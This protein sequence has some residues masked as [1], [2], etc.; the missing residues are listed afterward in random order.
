MKDIINTSVFNEINKKELK[1]KV[2]F[3]LAR[4][5]REINKEI[6]LYQSSKKELFDKY[7]I[8]NNDGTWKVDDQGNMHVPPEEIDN[9]NKDFNDLLN[10]IIKLNV[11]PINLDDLNNETFTIE[12]MNILSL[13]M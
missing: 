7:V 10:T 3:Q 4:I 11:E 8:K 9:F 1:A 5:A 13:F 2:A 12:Q 6:E